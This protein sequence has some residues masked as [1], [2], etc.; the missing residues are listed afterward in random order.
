MSAALI[1]FLVLQGLAFLI[2]TILAF[3]WLFAI[4]AEAVAQSGSHWPGM[5]IQLQAFRAGFV[6]GRYRAHRRALLLMTAIL[7]LL[8][9]I[10]TQIIR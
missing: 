9:G 6:D 3:R 2:W 1:Y 4:R 10:S 7:L 8:A 5:A